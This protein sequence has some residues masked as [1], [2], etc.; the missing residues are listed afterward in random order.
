MENT[1][2]RSQNMISSQQQNQGQVKIRFFL[3]KVKLGHMG[4][5]K[6]LPMTLPIKAYTLEEALIKARNHG[7]VK[8][9]H[10]DWCLEKPVEVDYEE[11]KSVHEET[12]SDAYWEGDARR[13]LSS[14]EARFI[15]EERYI[16]EQ[17]EEE[18]RV[19]KKKNRKPVRNAR[20][21]NNYYDDCF[22]EINELFYTEDEYDTLEV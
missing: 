4:K 9:D 21:N 13:N 20:A 22:D 15:D 11:Y 18:R 6:Y 7:G 3:I 17:K 12:Y 8:R 2:S 1:N 5:T 16:E 14:Y 10:L 19:E